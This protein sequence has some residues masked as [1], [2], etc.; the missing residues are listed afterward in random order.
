MQLIIKRRVSFVHHYKI[1]ST[2]EG[3][4]SLVEAKITNPILYKKERKNKKNDSTI[5]K[6]F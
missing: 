1:G 4:S 2:L 3:K 5:D 6:K